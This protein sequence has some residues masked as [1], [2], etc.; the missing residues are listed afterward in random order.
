MKK[1]IVIVT[2]EIETALP[3]RELKAAR[4]DKALVCGDVVHQVQV[5]VIKATK[6]P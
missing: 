2:L 1:R 6:K 3:V 4:W 5:D